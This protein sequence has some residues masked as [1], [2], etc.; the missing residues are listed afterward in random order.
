MRTNEKPTSIS[1]LFFGAT[2]D[3]VGKREIEIDLVD[4]ATVGGVLEQLKQANPGLGKHKLLFALNEVYVE[5]E[6]EIKEGDTLA[7]FTAVSGG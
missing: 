6:T 3:A 4:G 5:R 2:A 1:I 7:V